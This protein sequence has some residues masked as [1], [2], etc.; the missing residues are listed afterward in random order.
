MS[1]SV[2]QGLLLGQGSE[3]LYQ[4]GFVFWGCWTG[5]IWQTDVKSGQRCWLWVGKLRAVIGVDQEY[6]LAAQLCLKC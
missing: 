1:F 5:R 6:A 2:D 4:K 3:E